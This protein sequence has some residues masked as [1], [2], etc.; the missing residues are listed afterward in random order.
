MDV[1]NLLKN[2]KLQLEQ[3]SQNFPYSLLLLADETIEAI[4]KYIHKSEVYVLKKDKEEIAVVCLYYIDDEFV[5]I[6]NI[7]VSEIFQSKGIGS[8]LIK[9]IQNIVKNK[10]FKS[11]IVGTPDC[12]FS[13]IN[14]YE[15]NGFK[16]YQIRKNFYIDNYKIPIIENGIML[17]DMQLLIYKF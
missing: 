7:A 17:K 1:S 2:E 8:F 12:S 16:K 11:L 10:G 15:K 4:D 9:Q 6:K 3:R 5:E 13:Q 14:F